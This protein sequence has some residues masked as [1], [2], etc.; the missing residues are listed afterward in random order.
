[1]LTLYLRMMNPTMNTIMGSMPTAT[2]VAEARAGLT[3]TTGERAEMWIKM[4]GKH[5]TIQWKK[6]QL[7]PEAALEQEQK[8][9]CK[10]AE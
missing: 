1:M 4:T 7:R 9:R 5:G 8:D 2:R 6:I 3:E 10:R